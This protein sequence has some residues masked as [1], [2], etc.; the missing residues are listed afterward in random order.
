VKEVAT[1]AQATQVLRD[2]CM[3]ARAEGHT[4][5]AEVGVMERIASGLG[6]SSTQVCRS[7]EG[8]VDLD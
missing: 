5:D 2:I 8:N 7:L 6:L 4:T 1:V 3:I